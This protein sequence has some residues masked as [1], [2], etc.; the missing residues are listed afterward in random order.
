M[1][2]RRAIS[3]QPTWSIWFHVNIVYVFNLHV[4]VV[5][6]AVCLTLFLVHTYFMLTNT[7]TWERIAR[8]KITYLNSLDDPISNP[9][10]EGYLKNMSRF[11]LCYLNGVKWNLI[12][13]HFMNKRS[14]S[15]PHMSFH[16]Q[17]DLQSTNNIDM[18]DSEC[19]T[20]TISFNFIRTDVNRS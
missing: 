8:H 7:T 12:Y 17:S 11:F 2:F 20:K 14:A 9:F 16:N 10:N 1:I 4:L 18:D 13:N 19:E 15:E 3:H 6:L 5:A